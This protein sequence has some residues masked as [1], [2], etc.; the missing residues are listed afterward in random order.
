M[1]TNN[2]ITLELD[3]EQKGSIKV[4]SQIIND[5]SSGIYSSPA[6][7]LKELVNNSFDADAEN[8]IIRMKPIEDSITIWDDGNG[9]NAKDFDEN[10]AW[11]SKSN[12]RNRGEFSPLHKRPLIGK[13]GIGFIAVNEICEVLEVTSSKKG[14]NVKFVA[15]IDFTK[16][17]NKENAKGQDDDVYLKGEFLL[18]NEKE[19]KDEHY[20][21][22]R[23]IGL[24]ETVLKIFNDE[25]YKAQMAKSNNKKFAKVSFKNMKDLLMHHNSSRSWE[26]D[27]EYIQFIIDF[28]SYIPVEYIEGGPI[29]GVND[30]IINDIVNV[31]KKFNFKVDFDGMYL[32]KPIFFP[33]QDKSKYDSFSKTIKT[34]NGELKFKGYFYINNGNILPR[35]LN[36]ISIRIKNIPIAERFGYDSTFTKYPMYTDL[37]FRNW[38]SGEIYIEKGLE[39]AMN[40]DRKSFRVTHPHYMALQEFIHQYLKETI[41]KITLEIYQAGKEV[42][43]E[44]K[45]KVNKENTE[46]ILKTEKVTYTAK[47]KEVKKNTSP[48]NRESPVKIIKSQNSE[49][50]IEIDT[51]IKKKYKKND[52]EFLEKVF[53]IFESAYNESQGDSKKLRKLFYSKIEDW[54][55]KK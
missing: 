35:E 50:V 13:I 49:T 16:I 28:A 3:K 2:N 51:T 5:L 32:K 37:I 54:K 45:S 34:D 44:N 19:D 46:R 41:F 31:H 33:S 9:M 52:W 26:K 21:S 7:C 15:T 47:P 43:E 20:T 39:D 53:I 22:I 24:K 4:H 11:I 42:R 55:A 14:E 38:I 1:E 8:V 10:F 17:I 25:T 36:G 40:I 29:E 6:S 12:K 48:Q 23:L 30:K 18:T 27:T